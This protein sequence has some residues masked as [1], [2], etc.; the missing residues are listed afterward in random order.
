MRGLICFQEDSVAKRKS[1]AFPQRLP[2]HNYMEKDY[3]AL[4]TKARITDHAF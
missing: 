3:Y 2:L 4:D 1:W